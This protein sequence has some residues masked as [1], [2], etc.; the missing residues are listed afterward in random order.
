M[1]NELDALL[2]AIR[3][4]PADDLP[5]LALSDWCM[6]QAD[7]AT[8]ARGELI[9]LRNRAAALPADS[10]ERGAMELRVQALR[11]EHE[12]EWL[13]GLGPYITGWDFERGMIVVELTAAS[14]H[15]AGIEQL[16][17]QPGWKWVIGLKGTLLSAGDVR[18]L[19]SSA[20]GPRLLLASLTTL[21]LCNCELGGE[22]VRGLASAPGVENLTSLRLGYACCG[23]EG[24][25]ALAES[26]QLSRLT[27]LELFNNG[28]SAAGAAA[29]AGSTRLR[30]LT[31]LDLSRNPLGDGGAR[32]LAHSPHFPELTE[33]ILASCG[34]GDR[35]SVA[36]VDTSLLQKLACLDLSDNVLGKMTRSELRGRYRERVMWGT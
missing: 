33:L 2:A 17:S 12:Q 27:A 36:F 11:M 31:R 24:A 19:L 30:R 8:Q 14:L 34:I 5:R 4:A 18:R 10:P 15:R 13:G 9:Q 23:D 20:D 25:L 32:S 26:N 22:G 16:R 28:I 35:G 3:E 7:R 21:D 29:L 1:T 6:E